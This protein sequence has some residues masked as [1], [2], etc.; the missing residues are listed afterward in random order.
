MVKL[1]DSVSTGVPT[2][3]VEVTKLGRTLKTPSR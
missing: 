3:L 1:I 2:A